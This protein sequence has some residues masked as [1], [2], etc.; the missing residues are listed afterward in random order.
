MCRQANWEKPVT[1][2]TQ[3][4]ERAAKYFCTDLCSRWN[5]SEKLLKAVFRWAIFQ[6]IFCVTWEKA[7]W[8]EPPNFAY[9]SSRHTLCSVQTIHLSSR[10]TTPQ[11]VFLPGDSCNLLVVSL[12]YFAEARTWPE[13]YSDLVLLFLFSVGCQHVLAG[14]RTK[15]DLVI[16]ATWLTLQCHV[17][18]VTWSQL[19]IP[20]RD[21][22][23][24]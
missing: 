10:E 19:H 3:H 6:R 16:K 9:F 8:N 12:Q 7:V 22:Q 18:Q 5:K 11:A 21:F 24:C 4:K 2:R 1:K 20:L 15:E 23:L 13:M 14:C 17:E